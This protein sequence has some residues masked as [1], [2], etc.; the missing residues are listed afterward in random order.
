MPFGF[1]SPRLHFRKVQLSSAESN[2]APLFSFSERE[3]V[4]ILPVPSIVICRQLAFVRYQVA[5]PDWKFHLSV[6]NIDGTGL[7][8]ITP[9]TLRDLLRPDW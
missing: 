7:K 5:Q 1:E 2:R 4:R 8:T 9:D 6:I 3:S